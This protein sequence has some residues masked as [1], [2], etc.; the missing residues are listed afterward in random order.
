[1]NRTYRADYSNYP[2]AHR[3]G[4][5]VRMVTRNEVTRSPQNLY[6]NLYSPNRTTKCPR[7]YGLQRVFRGRRLFKAPILGRPINNLWL[8][9]SDRDT[10]LG[11]INRRQP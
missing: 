2:H 3:T 1:M 7:T 4:T 6:L 11:T 5:T 9:T 8:V 10:G